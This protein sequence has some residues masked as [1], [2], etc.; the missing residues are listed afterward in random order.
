VDGGHRNNHRHLQ[1]LFHKGL[2]NRF[3]LP[4]LHGRPGEFCYFI[5]ALPSFRLLIDKGLIAPDDADRQRREELIRLN[6]QKAYGELHRDPDQQ[7]KLM[8][9]QHE[10]MI[11][12]FHGVLELACKKFAGKVVLEVW[13]Q[14]AELWQQVEVPAVRVE[15]GR[16]LDLGKTELLP[17]RPDA[18][19]T[20][21]F[22]GN[23]ED[24]QRSHFMYEADR[25]TENT[26]RFKLKLR[27]HWHFIVK[28]NRHRVAAP[29]TVH[30][31]RAV[32]TE[33]TTSQW[34][35]N[36]RLAAKEPIVSPRPSPL[37]WFTTSELFTKPM[38]AGKRNVPLYLVQPEV[39]FKRIWAS[40][41]E[42]KFLN[43]AD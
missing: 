42:D 18:F 9:I 29:Y 32:L 21:Y 2:V 16:V 34:A 31:I 4:T 36:L 15:D 20:L 5:D 6:H 41:A 7:G 8:F 23:P 1:T 43:L 33:S 35:H 27:A 13:K 10:L 12:R 28:Q 14:G 11:S 24:K 22:P 19:F 38:P 30:A 26:T 37:F 40:P 39:I 17:H 25:R 3:A